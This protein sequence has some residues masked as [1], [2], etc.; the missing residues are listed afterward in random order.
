MEELTLPW[1]DE[2]PAAGSAHELP[3]AS[4]SEPE[5]VLTVSEVNRLAK[6]ALEKLTVSVRGEVSGLNTRYPYYVYL[7]LR[8]SEASLPA[9]VTRRMF[10]ALDFNLEEGI[11]VVV[12]GTLSLYERQG[13]YQIRVTEI[14]PFGEGEIQLRIEALKK[15]LHAEGLFEAACKKSLPRF[16]QR[17][18]L[19][20]S[21]RGAAIRDV[22]VTLARRFPPVEVFVRS[23]MVQGGG[24]ARQICKALELFD[25]SWPVDLVILARGGGSIQDLEPFSTEPVARTLARLTVPVVTGIGHEP[26][27]SIADLVADL[28]AST[29]TAAAE[30]SVPDR[31]EVL[32]FLA[33]TGSVLRRHAQADLQ[34]ASR[35]LG[36]LRRLPLYRTAD[37]LLGRFM[38]RFER[39]TAA[40]PESP[41]RGLLKN[42]HRLAVLASRPVYRIPGMLTAHADRELEARASRLCLA[43][44]RA[45]ERECGNLERIMA[46]ARALSPLAV[47]ER[48]YSIT[49]NKD[50]GAVVRS[51]DEVEIGTS[52]K[53][54]LAAGELDAEVTGKE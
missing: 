44:A 24:A 23:V 30:A 46:R 3:E 28:R 2:E 15:K 13:R 40:L 51:P 9:I 36:A 10:E 17:I 32:A 38:Q 26:D 54:R 43:A 21:T 35:H 22:T 53:L 14:R 12:R 47:L 16:P 45:V 39:S 48:G 8:D 37:F 29:P 11:S 25:S 34:S 49:F 7:D 5:K 1:D 4:A 42:R 18:G 52:L 27:V 19:V 6:L 33:K 50:T 31:L 41:R 20:T